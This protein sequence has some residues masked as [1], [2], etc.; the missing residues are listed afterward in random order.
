M[1]RS[2]F[3]AGLAALA[4]LL[5]AGTASAA[6]ESRFLSQAVPASLSAGS[7]T[8]VSL[9][10]MN[11][12]TTSWTVPGGYTLACPDVGTAGTWEVDTVGLPGPVEAGT[13]VTFT[14]RVTAPTTPGTYNFQWRMQHGT[15]FFGAAST[16]VP[17]KVFVRSGAANPASPPA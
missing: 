6:D 9:T 10:F 12:G 1:A 15:T 11:T 17:I 16:S 2:R 5:V 14:F 7:S 3:A 13:S 4:V 8:S